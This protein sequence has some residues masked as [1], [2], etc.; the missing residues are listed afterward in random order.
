M[1]ED[2]SKKAKEVSF[3]LASISGEDKNKAL[4]KIADALEKNKKK[5]LEANK[6]DLEANKDINKSLYKR[7]EISEEKFS[8]MVDGVKSLI[9]LDDPVGKKLSSTL[10]DDGLVLDKVSVPIGVIGVIFESRPDA[11]VQ[12]SCLCIKSGNCAILKG[13]SEANNTNKFLSELIRGAIG[14]VIPKDAIQL[15]S[16]R[17][18]VKEMLSMEKY[19]DLI[20]PRG[21]NSLVQYIMKN[22]SIPVL[23]HADGICHVYV[24]D[25]ADLEMAKKIVVDSKCQYAAVCNAM[26]T[27]LVNSKIASEFL[28]VVKKEYDEKGVKLMGCSETMKIIDVD[29]AIEKEWSTEY[30]DLILSIK[31]VKDIDEAIDHINKYASHHTDCIVSKSEEKQKKFISLVDSA[32][33]FVNAST[34]FAD[35]YRYGFGAEVGISTNKIHAR[36]PVGL[37]GLVIYKYILNGKGH[38]VAD[39]AS[40]KKKFKHKSIK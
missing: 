6:K 36:G 7:L 22:T 39:Y 2:I 37:E 4:G 21:S 23:G 35:G 31:V 40:G 9:G 30:N 17:E 1:I 3:K 18:D 12:I 25:E 8:E 15:I 20:I 32:S 29:E 5:L 10:L 24:D 14:E 13:G 33:V 38:I 19:I 27:L 11:L 16:T 34:R 26:E 28:P